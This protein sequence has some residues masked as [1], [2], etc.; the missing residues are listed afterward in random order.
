MLVSQRSM[1]QKNSRKFLKNSEKI[2]KKVKILKN[3]QNFKKFGVNCM[4]FFSFLRILSTAFLNF[5]ETENFVSYPKNFEYL[6]L[7]IAEN[8]SIVLYQTVLYGTI[9]SVPYVI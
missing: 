9:L 8:F 3:P 7:K 2:R 1:I 5:L 6:F 4:I